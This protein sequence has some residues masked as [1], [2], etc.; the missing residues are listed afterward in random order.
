MWQSR[1]GRSSPQS[2]IHI[3][4]VASRCRTP[5]CCL[6][7]RHSLRF[8]RDSQMYGRTVTSGSTMVERN[9]ES[10]SRMMCY[11]LIIF[12]GSCPETQ[13]L[14][15]D[16]LTMKEP[17]R[18]AS[19]ALGSC[20]PKHK[21]GS[22]YSKDPSMHFRD[23]SSDVQLTLDFSISNPD[24]FAIHKFCE[25]DLLILLVFHLLQRSL[26]EFAHRSLLHLCRIPEFF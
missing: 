20:F 23:F 17:R 24:C 4:I 15:F 14:G 25:D 26:L 19:S 13:S 12:A 11:A 2:S 8:G 5:G 21:S 3:G 10:G 22:P 6:L 18:G 7:L 9:R 1:K 16:L